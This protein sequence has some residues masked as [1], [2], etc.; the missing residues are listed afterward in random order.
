MSSS[1]SAT[2]FKSRNVTG[3]SKEA[4]EAFKLSGDTLSTD[5]APR[6][7]MQT[8]ISPTTKTISPEG[9]TTGF[10]GEFANTTQE[11]VDQL[12]NSFLLRQKQITQRKAQ[13]GRGALFLQR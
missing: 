6:T 13:P 12:T 4:F 1:S 11:E 9:N 2:G 5:K 10:L 8:S 7:K 3:F